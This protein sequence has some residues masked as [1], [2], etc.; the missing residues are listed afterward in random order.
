M[1]PSLSRGTALHW[2]GGPL[3]PDELDVRPLLLAADRGVG[4]P[5]LPPNGHS[6]RP[7]NAGGAVAAD[8]LRPRPVPLV[9]GGGFAD[10]RVRR[11]AVLLRAH[12]AAHPARRPRAAVLRRRPDRSDPAAGA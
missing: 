12:D 3:A 4:L 10:P 1:R 7:R 8:R 6:R 2:S 11:E 5:L 9:H